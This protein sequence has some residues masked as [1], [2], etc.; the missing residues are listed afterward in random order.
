MTPNSED[1]NGKNEGQEALGCPMVARGG[2]DDPGQDVGANQGGS[3]LGRSFRFLIFERAQISGRA[4]KNVRPGT[5]V[6]LDARSAAFM[7]WV[8]VRLVWVSVGALVW[9]C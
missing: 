1:A 4:S 5:R 3:A 2:R 9:S 8:S 7:V 6:R